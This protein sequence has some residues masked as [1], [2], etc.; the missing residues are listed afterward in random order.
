MIDLHFWP[1]PNGYKI[2]IFLEESGLDYRLKPV[3]IGR[4]DQ[5]KP[6]YLAISPNNKMP[7]IVDHAPV[8]GGGPVSVFESG[9]IL[10]YLADKAGAFAG[11]SPRQ[12]IQVQEWLFWQ[13][14]G[15]GPMAGQNHHFSAY[16]AE[17]V[18]YAIDRYVNETTRLYR[19]LNQ[20]L[21]GRDYVADDYSIAD[22]AAYPW[23]RSWEKQQQTLTDHPHLAAWK[24]RVEARPAV[25]LAYE[26]GEQVSDGPLMTEDAKKLLFGQR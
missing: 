3:H 9:A 10:N 8:D 6:E 13:V 5:F 19:V 21:D 25:A 22:M 12:R 26:I 24:A 14:G 15:L 16:A 1:T 23:I 4:G 7:A 11:S 2:L 18:P 20:R 17:R